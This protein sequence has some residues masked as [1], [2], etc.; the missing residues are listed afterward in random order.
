[1]NLLSCIIGTLSV[2]RQ[3]PDLEVSLGI[4]DCVRRSGKND[5]PGTVIKK[6]SKNFLQTRKNRNL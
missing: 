5:R 2:S 6:N 1:M 4:F 3:L